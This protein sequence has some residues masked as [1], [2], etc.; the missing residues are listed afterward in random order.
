ELAHAASALG[1]WLAAFQ[2]TR[3]PVE[4]RAAV[5]TLIARARR[6][7][8]KAPLSRLTKRSVGRRVESLAAAMGPPIAVP[9][10]GDLWPGNVFVAPDRVTVIDFEGFRTG[11]PA[12]DLACFLVHA[13]L[14]LAW[15]HPLIHGALEK[16]LFEGYGMPADEDELR[17]ARIACA[18][19][20]LAR[21]DADAPFLRRVVHR[22]ILGRELSS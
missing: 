1:A 10:H 13:K 17:L 18:L 8:R 6:D 14:Y 2:E 9:H 21:E 15:R 5:E 3:P 20:L 4:G 19:H 11:L 22:M 12:E 7:L 16:Q